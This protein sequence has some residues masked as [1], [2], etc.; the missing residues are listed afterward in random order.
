MSIAC[1][2]LPPGTWQKGSGKGVACCTMIGSSADGSVKAENR[3]WC[4]CGRESCKVSKRSRLARKAK[5]IGLAR[6]VAPH[7]RERLREGQ[8][9]PTSPRA[10]MS[11]GR[12][13]LPP[14]SCSAC[15]QTCCAGWSAP[16][17]GADCHD[18]HHF[19]VQEGEMGASEPSMFHLTPCERASRD[20]PKVRPTSVPSLH[21]MYSS[22]NY[23][24][25]II[26]LLWQAF[27]VFSDITLD[28]IF[29]LSASNTKGIE[30]RIR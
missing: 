22:V 26:N 30:D 20:I 25:D 11:W 21:M 6:S 29:S 1:R 10:A 18:V 2:S 7:K 9:A 14:C 17:P 27:A 5:N 4:R 16:D 28:P 12:S 23:K 8:T 13:C 3:V 15:H 24:C 19:R